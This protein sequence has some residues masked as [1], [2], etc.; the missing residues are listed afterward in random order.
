MFYV[1]LYCDQ[2]NANLLLSTRD[3]PYLALLNR[4]KYLYK[5]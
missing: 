2:V 3:E 1:F 4:V 5:P